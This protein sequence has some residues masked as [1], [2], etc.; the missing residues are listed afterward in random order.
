MKNLTA[1][2]RILFGVW[3][4]LPTILGD[5]LLGI[6]AFRF[7]NAPEA[8]KGMA[9]APVPDW[10]LALSALLGVASVALFAVGALEL[11]RVMEQKYGLGGMYSNGYESLGWLLMYLV[12]AMKLVDER[13]R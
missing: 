9:F 7:S 12:C 11:L 5:Y 4:M 1:R 8:Y 13:D 10:R 6:N 2:Q 3:A